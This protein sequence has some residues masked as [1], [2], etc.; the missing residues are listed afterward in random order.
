MCLQIRCVDK[1]RA[2]CAVVTVCYS[3]AM[4]QMIP[5]SMI[6]WRTEILRRIACRKSDR[7]IARETHHGCHL[8]RG[9][10][11]GLNSPDDLFTRMRILA[12]HRKVTSGLIAEANP[13]ARRDP[14]LGCKFLRRILAELSV[15]QSVS[16]STVDKIFGSIG[17]T[18][19]WCSSS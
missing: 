12:A 5:M 11:R 3:A 9:I 19:R 4:K 13:L 18:L 17:L 1:S 7:W 16:K 10:R 14:E 15:F 2:T 6:H 8:V